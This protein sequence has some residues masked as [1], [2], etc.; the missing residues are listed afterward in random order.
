[1][2]LFPPQPHPSLASPSPACKASLGTEGFEL[3]EEIL[4]TV[5]PVCVGVGGYGI[6]TGGSGPRS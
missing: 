4:N 5:S 3:V 6:G 1:M 2:G